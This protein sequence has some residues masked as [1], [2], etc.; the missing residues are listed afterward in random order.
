MSVETEDTMRHTPTLR[1][2]LSQGEFAV[3]DTDDYPL[4]ASR[5]WMLSKGYAVT[6]MSRRSTTP[7]RRILMHHLI[8][9]EKRMV[10]HRDGDGLN[11]RRNNLR[12]CTPQQNLQNMRPKANHLPYKGIYFNKKTRRY[13]AQIT[14]DYKKRFLGRFDNPL[15]AA[16]AYDREALKL[17]GEFA[18]LNFPQGSES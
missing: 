11:N 8:I 14:L 17:F 6:E 7:R 4:V 3:I 12:T 16:I 9:G 10:D 5:T 18:R 13:Q 1:I 2:P 15:S